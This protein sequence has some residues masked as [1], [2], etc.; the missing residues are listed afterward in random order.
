MSAIPHVCQQSQ[1][2]SS[3]KNLLSQVSGSHY[4]CGVPARQRSFPQGTS[5]APRAIA[6]WSI[7]STDKF[8]HAQ[9]FACAKTPW[10]NKRPGRVTQDKWYRRNSGL[11][12]STVYFLLLKTAH[13][14][15][16]KKVCIKHSLLVNAV[17]KLPF[18]FF[19]FCVIELAHNL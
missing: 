16:N 13:N 1:H 3:G 11:C 10:F 15:T 7:L 9:N 2:S 6:S 4:L 14:D 8:R 18:F 17:A 12:R 19:L 5:P